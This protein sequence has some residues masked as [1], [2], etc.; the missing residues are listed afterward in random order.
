[1][2]GVN[3]GPVI[4][5]Q[6]FGYYAFWTFGNDFDVQFFIPRKGTLVA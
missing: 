4:N 2:A 6:Q 5:A 3:M 1:M